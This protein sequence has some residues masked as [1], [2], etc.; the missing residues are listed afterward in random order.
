MGV[1][2]AGEEVVVYFLP[3]YLKLYRSSSKPNQAEKEGKESKDLLRRSSKGKES[4]RGS[5]NPLGGAPNG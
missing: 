5:S 2:N 1:G 4:E 3:A